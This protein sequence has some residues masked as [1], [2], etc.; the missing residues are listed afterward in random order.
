LP[1]SYFVNGRRGRLCGVAVC[2]FLNA[3]RRRGERAADSAFRP[4]GRAAC[5]P[6]VVC[7]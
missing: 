2:A 5:L 6:R 4:R 7:S 1:G 3:D